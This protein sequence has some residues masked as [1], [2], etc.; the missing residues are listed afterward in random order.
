MFMFTPKE[1]AEL[2]KALGLTV[3]EF[4]KKLGVHR[5]SV[6]QWEAGITH[7]RYPKMMEMNRLAKQASA[8]IPER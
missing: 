5:D 1:I 7:P 6:Y 3:A 4:A 2:R 8:S